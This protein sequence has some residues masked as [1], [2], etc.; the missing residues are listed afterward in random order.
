VTSQNDLTL[1][2]N[3]AIACGSWQ[4]LTLAGVIALELGAPR[5]DFAH[6]RGGG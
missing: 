6:T 3:F 1:H 2:D 5:T 4:E